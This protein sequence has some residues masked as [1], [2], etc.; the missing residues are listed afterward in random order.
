MGQTK[1]NKKIA[2]YGGAFSPPHIGHAITMENIIRLFPCDEIWVM[3]S[4][5]R[6][7]KK[8]GV[9]RNHRL[10]MLDLFLRDFFPRPKVIIQISRV[11]LDRP[12]L[13]TTYETKIELE[14]QYPNYE[15]YFIIGADIL[16]D[17][18]QKWVRGKKLFDTANFIVIKRPCVAMPRSLPSKLTILDENVIKDDTSST[19]VRK[20]LSQGFS[21]MPYITNKIANY[22]KNN[23]LYQ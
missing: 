18:K 12:K 23:Q 13:T 19:F 4:A 3:P 5:D 8:I 2:I 20:L 15:F 22:I 7:D 9:N 1:V 17:I 11:E 21:G 14:K 16:G 10:K 6:L